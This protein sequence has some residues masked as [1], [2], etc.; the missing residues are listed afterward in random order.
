M[1]RLIC[2]DPPDCVSRDKCIIRK[3]RIT[4]GVREAGLREGGRKTFQVVRTERRT[5]RWMKGNTISPFTQLPCDGAQ[6]CTPQ[7]Y[8]PYY[9]QSVSR[10]EYVPCSFLEPETWGLTSLMVQAMTSE[11]QQQKSTSLYGNTISSLILHSAYCSILMLDRN[12][13]G[14]M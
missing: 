3:L 14:L 9:I 13:A 12:K 11:I 8:Q 5:D 2:I 7:K 4:L 6:K 10:L 1:I